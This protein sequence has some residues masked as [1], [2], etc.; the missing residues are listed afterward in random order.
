MVTAV[1]RDTPLFDFA[2]LVLTEAFQRNGIKFKLEAVPAL[3]AIELVNTGVADGDAFRIYEFGEANPN[4]FRIEEPYYSLDF[5]G[6][7]AKPDIQL[8][9]WASLKEGHYRVGYRAGVKKMEDNLVGFIDEDKLITVPG[10]A[11]EGFKML[12]A[13]RFDVFVTTPEAVALIQSNNFKD[14]YNAGVLDA[15]LIYPYLHKKHANLAPQIAA[16]IKEMKEEGLLERYREQ[17]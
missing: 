14:V 12:T 4:Y 8:D 10:D 7:A 1:E 16:T 9:G 17:Q 15:T 6:F 5:V 3:R 11:T 13:G 2:N